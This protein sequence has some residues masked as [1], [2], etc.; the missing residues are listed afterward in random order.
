MA[1]RGRSTSLGVKRGSRE[2]E[3]HWR[4]VLA[5]WSGSGQSKVAFCRER[6]LS[7]SAFHWWKGE[8]ARRDAAQMKHS[9]RGG[10]GQHP[11]E[12]QASSFVPLRL[13]ASPGHSLVGPASGPASEC[14]GLEVVLANGR[15]V[16]VGSGFD[17]GLLARVVSVLEGLAC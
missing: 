17:A 7:P 16:R 12:G 1:R 14:A 8:L 9:P 5:A 4:Q 2:R 15:R 3:A 6:G 10:A 11:G 13:V